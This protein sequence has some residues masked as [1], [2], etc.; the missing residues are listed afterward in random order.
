MLNERELTKAELNKREEVL[1]DLK[2]QKK[3]LVKRYGKDA[4]AVMYG[5]ATN[6]AKKQAESMNK[7]KL[8]KLVRTSLTKEATFTDEYDDNP[9]L[10]GDQKNLPDELQKGIID[11]ETT[12]K[13]GDKVTYLGHPGEITGVNKEMTGAITY[14]VAYDKGNGRTKVSN[15][16]N[17]G[18]EI[19]PLN[20]NKPV[21]N[22]NRHIK[23]IQIQ[24]DQLGVKYEMSGNPHKPFK[25][26]YR[27]INKDNK[28]YD[29][30]EDIVFRYNLRGVVQTSIDEAKSISDY[31][32]GDI[33]SFK[34]G[35]DWKVMKVKDNIGK[36]VIKPHNE[37]AK[38][39]NVSLEIDIDADYLKNNLSEATKNAN[40]IKVL[41]TRRAELMRD[42]EQEAELEGGP[43]ADRYGAMLNKID[44]AIA[45]LSG[46]GEWGPETDPYMDKGEIERRAAMIR[47][48]GG[49]KMEALMELQNILDELQTLGDQA[50]DIIAQNFPSYLSKGEAY[51][52]FDL[53]FWRN[54]YDTTLAS[55]VDEIEEYGDEEEGDEEMMQEGIPTV[56]DDKSMDDL[57]NII[58][59]YVEDPADAEKELERFDAGGFEAMSDSVQA[60]LDRDEEYKAWY[61]KLHSIEED[62]DLGHQDNEPHMLKADLY[63]IGKYA[64]ELYQMVDQFEGPGEVDFPHWWQAKIIKAKD[65]LVG[66]KHYLD[67]ETKEPEIDAM[68]DKV[69]DMEVFDNVGVET[70]DELFENKDSKYTVIRTGGSVGD[71]SFKEEFD[72]EEKAKEYAKRMNNQLSPGEKKYYKI[73]YKVIA[74]KNKPVFEEKTLAEKIAKQ[75]K[76]K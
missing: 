18:G 26:V 67:F 30:F 53:G 17:K 48:I 60:N 2:K 19:K 11:E 62:L 36:L 75:L 34:D 31:K 4:E 22:V 74:P 20:E 50:R 43:I 66:A 46:T 33:L 54:R 37:K 8:K 12:F 1:K 9:K 71:K 57:L 73:K 40:K 27:P 21:A 63:R 23:A 5:R 49:D 45:K 68:L 59:K 35:E 58:L 56:F 25:A 61:N 16:S 51:G 15:L 42:M 13:K 14:N 69:E 44:A 3:S 41:K 64:M 10:K 76:S 28:W 65:Y 39:G 52:A 55:I 29:N 24:L 72:S 47:E 38:K 6:I 7:E 32:I 70:E